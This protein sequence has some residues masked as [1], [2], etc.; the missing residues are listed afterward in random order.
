MAEGKNIPLGM[1]LMDS[2]FDGGVPPG[3]SILLSGATGTGVRE[4][5]YT[6]V[7]M[8]AMARHD[9][10]LF[11][12]HHEL[13]S[14][15]MEVPGEVHYVTL[16]RSEDT[17]LREMENSL[18]DEM[19]QLVKE[20][21]VFKDL[22]R[23]YFQ[24]SVVPISWIQGE[25]PNLDS[26]NTKGEISDMTLL[27]AF[28]EYLSKQASEDLVVIDSLT[29]MVRATKHELSWGELVVFLE[30][31]QRANKRWGGLIYGLLNDK[32]LSADEFEDISSILDGVFRF[33]WEEGDTKRQRLM[34]VESFRGL[35]GRLSSHQ[36]D[37][38]ETEVTESGFEISSIRK[39]K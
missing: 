30:G 18:N 3:S 6:S 10:D 15:D 12:I 28:A 33:E 29:S 16:T 7:A 14:E 11:S 8:T 37:K 5:A 1:S 4:Y 35:M 34:Y 27:A 31:L 9:P 25:S 13:T 24:N 23:N 26:L 36:K 21:V 20:H 38:F 17:L 2:M 39:I 19:F 22:S 32:T